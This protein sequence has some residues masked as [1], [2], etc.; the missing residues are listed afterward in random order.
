MLF[1]RFF[2]HDLDICIGSFRRFERD[3]D[4]GEFLSRLPQYSSLLSYYGHPKLVMNLLTSIHQLKHLAKFQR[5]V[6]DYICE[7]SRCLVTDVLQE[8][9][10]SRLGGMLSTSSTTNVEQIETKSITQLYKLPIQ[11]VING[12]NRN[13]DI[14]EMDRR[15]ERLEGKKY[16]ESKNMIGA[17]ILEVFGMILNGA[18][19]FKHLMPFDKE[20]VGFESIKGVKF[21]IVHTKVLLNKQFKKSETTKRITIQ[22]MLDEIEVFRQWLKDNNVGDDVLQKTVTD[23]KAILKEKSIKVNS[24][25]GTFQ[26]HAAWQDLKGARGKEIEIEK[27]AEQE[28]IRKEIEKRV[29]EERRKTSSK[30]RVKIPKRQFG[31]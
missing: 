9:Q 2:E 27:Q 31:E 23:A 11:E 20:K 19:C 12:K 7:N 26:M 24:W 16:D 17:S 18:E 15:L 1:L 21:Q 8:L 4:F 25:A 14:C 28:V 10:N 29:E 3:G 6:F 13:K 30:G 22:M 5:P